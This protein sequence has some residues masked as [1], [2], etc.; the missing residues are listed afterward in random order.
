MSCKFS[1]AYFLDKAS[2]VENYGKYFE[3]SSAE[4]FTQSAKKC[5][6]YENPFPLMKI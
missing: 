2:F 5:G 6:F 3:L 4:N 1:K